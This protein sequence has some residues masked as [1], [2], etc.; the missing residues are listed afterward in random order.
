MGFK[1]ESSSSS[2]EKNEDKNEDKNDVKENCL[3]LQNVEENVLTIP[4]TK[5]SFLQPESDRLEREKKSLKSGKKNISVGAYRP[6]FDEKKEK[7][8]ARGNIVFVAVFTLLPVF[9]F[10]HFV[11]NKFSSLCENLGYY[12]FSAI[13]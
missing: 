13:S 7:N 2:N 8:A 5:P 4:L 1:K 11:F 6:Q 10:I 3:L 9:L 12:L